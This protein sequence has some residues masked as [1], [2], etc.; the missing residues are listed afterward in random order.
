VLAIVT[1]VS[2]V[3]RAH[4]NWA[5]T[6]VISGIMLVVVVLVRFEAWRWLKAGLIVGNI[7][8]ALLLAGDTVADRLTVP[9]IAKGDIY[10]HTMGWRALGNEAARLAHEANAKT[11]AASRRDD[12]ASLVYYLRN[13]PLSVR[14]WP[15]SATIAD[16][17]QLTRPL[18]ATAAEPVLLIARCPA[19]IGLNDFYANVEPL[20]PFQARS[21]PTSARSYFAFKLSGRKAGALSKIC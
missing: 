10:Q 6:A 16:H 8:Q 3:T 14:A 18:T 17:F 11:V 7:V 9:G 15:D 12:V 1:A 20:G 5:A 4:A 2:F 21:G 13:E 19:P